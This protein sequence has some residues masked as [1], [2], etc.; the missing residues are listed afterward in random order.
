MAQ[1]APAT[2]VRIFALVSLGVGLFALAVLPWLREAMSLD[3]TLG[4]HAHDGYVELARSLIRGEGFVFEAGGEP[5]FHRPPLY[6]LLIAPAMLLPEGAQRAVLSA[7]DVLFLAGTCSLVFHLARLW[8]APWA[9]AAAAVLIS[10]NPWILLK[11]GVGMPPLMQV[12]LFT[13]LVVAG[14]RALEEPRDPGAG[15]RRGLLVGLSAAAL[16]LTHGAMIASVALLFGAA[17]LWSLV[18]RRWASLRALA[19]AVALV[20]ACVAPWTLRNHQVTGRPIPVA[21]NMGFAYFVAKAHWQEVPPG[22]RDRIEEGLLFGQETSRAALLI[23]G[24]EG[25]IEQHYHFY[26]L[27]DPALDAEL[28]RRMMA[29]LRAEPLAYARRVGLNAIDYVAPIVW[30]LVLRGDAGLLDTLWRW[31]LKSA[32]TLATCGIALLAIAGVLRSRGAVRTRGAVLLFAVGAFAAPYV[33][34]LTGRSDYVLGA[35]PLLS[36]LAA[37]GLPFTPRLGLQGP[38]T[39]SVGAVGE[40]SSPSQGRS[41]KRH[42]TRAIAHSTVHSMSDFSR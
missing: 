23:A 37:L 19:V 39:G 24:V 18:G 11:V 12:F 8:F 36:L 13:A 25:P 4:G 6:P 33:I 35:L 2:E 15:L 26:G 20:A 22:L 30:P 40:S 28:G 14:V 10:A 9:G 27:K 31:K 21:G 42:T 32:R 41:T 16:V 38:W 17:L 1:R 34:V 3:L 29:D 5:V 7:L